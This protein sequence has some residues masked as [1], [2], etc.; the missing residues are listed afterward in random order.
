[1]KRHA[2]G[3]ILLIGLYLGLSNGYLALFKTGTQTPEITLPYRAA[4]YPKI[5]Q[6]ELS[7]GIVIKSQEHLK[8]IL[9]DFLS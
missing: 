4:V 6:Q 5:D 3:I 2:L 9:E 7:R 1:M 8:S